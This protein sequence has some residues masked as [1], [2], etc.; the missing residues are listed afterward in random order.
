MPEFLCLTYHLSSNLL[1][2][3][4]G[5]S[6]STNDFLHPQEHS[7]R[8][9]HSQRYQPNK[10]SSKH[11]ANYDGADEYA[12]AQG[13][14]ALLERLEHGLEADG[15][16]RVEEHVGLFAMNWYISGSACGDWVWWCSDILSMLVLCERL[17][18]VCLQRLQGVS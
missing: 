14:S 8:Q 9:A 16:R 4:L 7:R 11:L 1:T 17:R 18:G 6:S 2:M 13:R 15:R 12:D 5:L 3:P 10:S